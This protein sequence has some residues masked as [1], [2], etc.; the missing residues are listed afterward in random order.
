MCTLPALPVLFVVCPAAASARVE[1]ITRAGPI[2]RME[3]TSSALP[4]A[5]GSFYLVLTYH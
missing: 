4:L 2:L 5:V 1:V 3:A